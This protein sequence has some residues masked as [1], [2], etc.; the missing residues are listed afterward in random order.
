VSFFWCSELSSGIYCRV[1][2]LSTDFRGANCLHHQG[3]VILH[4]SISQKTTLNIILAA[5]RTLN[6]TCPSLSTAYSYSP[7]SFSSFFIFFY[8]AS[9]RFRAICSPTFFL[10][11]SEVSV[12][13]YK[14]IQVLQDGVV[15]PCPTPTWRTRVPLLVWVI[16][17]NLSAKGAPASSCASAGIALRILW[18][19]KPRQSRDTFGW[20]LPSICA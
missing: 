11:S 13:V 9:V 14:K 16:T 2:W 7:S 8:S 19:H 6:L 10:H 17:F 3:W 18:P 15:S 12:E 20:E 5:V 1:K 4:S